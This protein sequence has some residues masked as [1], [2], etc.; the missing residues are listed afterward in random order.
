LEEV[1][2][3]SVSDIKIACALS[4]RNGLTSHKDFQRVSQDLI[5]SK[6]IM[7]SRLSWVQILNRYSNRPYENESMYETVE[8]SL[9]MFHRM[10]EHNC[11]QPKQFVQDLFDVMEMRLPKIN[12]FFIQGTKNAGKSLLL[13]SVA[14][15][16]IYSAYCNQFLYQNRFSFQDLMFQRVCFVNEVQLDDLTV[17]VFKGIMEGMP[18]SV[19]RKYQSAQLLRRVPIIMTANKFPSDD[20]KFRST[21][22]SAIRARMC[23]YM[24]HTMNDLQYFKLQFNPRMWSELIEMYVEK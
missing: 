11:I 17:E 2:P 23:Y 16:C 19:D 8:R 5:D 12:T 9:N 4:N 18:T 7:F 20:L 14:E 24:F 6:K 10:M 15:S 22:E 3:V 21:H 1:T 13:K